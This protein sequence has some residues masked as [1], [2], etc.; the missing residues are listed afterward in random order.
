MTS[1]VKLEAEIKAIIIV[2]LLAI[3]SLNAFDIFYPKNVV[4]T[5]KECD[6]T[7]ITYSN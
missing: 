3:V 6:G 5:Y 7:K 4:V 2:L 1:I